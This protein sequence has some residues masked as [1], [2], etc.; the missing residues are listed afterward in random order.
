MLHPRQQIHALYRQ[1][2][3]TGTLL[4]HPPRLHGRAIAY[5]AETETE[6]GDKSSA[7]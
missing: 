1:Q 6:T 7:A 5:L 4:H 3:T 2:T